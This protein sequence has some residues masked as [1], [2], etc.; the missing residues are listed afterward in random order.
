MPFSSK[1]NKHDFYMQKHI[2]E[3]NSIEIQ[4]HFT[5]LRKPLFRDLYFGPLQ[6]K[7]DLGNWEDVS[8]N[9]VLG[10]RHY[11]EIQKQP[12]MFHLEKPSLQAYKGILQLSYFHWEWDKGTALHY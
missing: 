5:A 12:D 4:I 3:E 6:L 2:K 1:T 10:N 8:R 7:Q 11:I 9:K